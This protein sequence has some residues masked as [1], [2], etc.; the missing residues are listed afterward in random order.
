[1]LA[2]WPG[3]GAGVGSESEDLGRWVGRKLSWGLLLLRFSDWKMPMLAS[4]VTVVQ[5]NRMS[6]N[7]LPPI[8]AW[9]VNRQIPFGNAP[10]EI[11]EQWVDVPLPLRQ[12]TL[13]ESPQFHIGYGLNNLFDVHI[14]NDGQAV[15]AFDAVKALKLFGRQEAADFWNE[16]LYPE[17][18]LIFKGN[19]GQVYPTSSL[20]RIL[21]G[22]EMFDHIAE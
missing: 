2:V 11:K 20:Q 21:P 6:K 14:H 17:D 7:E 10:R 12:L 22:I 1:M 8:Q 18:T 19:E 16:M 5:T 9:F 13:D 15:Y 4:A 3:F